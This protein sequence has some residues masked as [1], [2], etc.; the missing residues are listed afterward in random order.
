[1]REKRTA[2][3]RPAFDD[4]VRTKK[5]TATFMEELLAGASSGQRNSWITK[6]FGTM[7]S[8]GMDFAAAYKWIKLINQNYL[9]P[10]LSN[11]ELNAI[12][13][14]ISKRENQKLDK[15]RGGLRGR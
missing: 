12:V 5:F 14:S 9:T 4:V 13:L 1:M 11:Q 3:S 10:P 6:Q 8:L 7:V 2:E 15:G